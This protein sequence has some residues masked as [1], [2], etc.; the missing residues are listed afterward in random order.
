M[1]SF[2]HISLNST[3]L[4]R[5]NL[6]YWL[7]KVNLIWS[8]AGEK[9][10]TIQRILKSKLKLA[11]NNLL[12]QFCQNWLENL[13]LERNRTT[14]KKI[15]VLYFIILFV[16][17]FTNIQVYLYDGLIPK[18][19]SKSANRKLFLLIYIIHAR[20]IRYLLSVW[21]VF[22]IIYW[23]YWQGQEV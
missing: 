8:G 21:Q 10:K 17:I 12:I 22:D 9:L 5:P 13:K 18:P 3:K 4:H 14:K 23:L 15:N 1:V 6:I 7:I 19:N 20:S 2:C 11:L 16:N